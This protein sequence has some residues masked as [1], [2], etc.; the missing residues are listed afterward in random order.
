MK[1]LIIGG[2]SDLG[3]YL[4]KSNKSEYDFT[5]FKKKIPGGIKFDLINDRASDLDL[6]NYESILILSAISN[7]TLCEQNPQYSRKLNVEATIKL[8]NHCINKN[9]KIIFFST[10]F[11]YNGSKGNYN[12]Q[13]H[14]DPINLYGQQ[15]LEV[16]NFIKN[17]SSKYSILRIAKTYTNNFNDQTLF[18]FFYKKIIKEKSKEIPIIEDE[19]FSPLY[20]GDLCDLI[21]YST[22]NDIKFLNIGGPERFSRADC[23][24]LFLSI[25]KKKN[26]EKKIYTRKNTSNDA[27]IP[28]DVSFNIN[29]VR[30][31]KKNMITIQY[32]LKNLYERIT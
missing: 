10:E 16:E 9:K 15:K 29:K 2:S 25:F 22:K 30:N 6:S 7:P 4:I 12:E 20:I 8:M 31:I 27:K 11:I 23:L 32:F 14:P 17:N 1:S 18:S 21:F 3:Q 13:D 28:K 19:Y 24:N 26:I 5:I